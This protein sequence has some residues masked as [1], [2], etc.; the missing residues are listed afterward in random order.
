MICTDRLF[1]Y[2]RAAIC[3]ILVSNALPTGSMLGVWEE[4]RV[5]ERALRQG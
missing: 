2:F 4:H 1:E 3:L 5:G